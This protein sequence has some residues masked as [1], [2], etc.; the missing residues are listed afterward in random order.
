MKLWQHKVP[1]SNWILQQHY[2]SLLV[3][4]LNA[5]SNQNWPTGF[6]I[7][8]GSKQTDQYITHS[9]VP[10]AS[11]HKSWPAQGLRARFPLVHGSVLFLPSTWLSIQFATFQNHTKHVAFLLI[12]S[13]SLSLSLFLCSNNFFQHAL[14]RGSLLARDTLI[15]AFHGRH[16]ALSL[17]IND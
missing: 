10:I 16:M 5:L 9:S 7:L 4:I 17:F 3:P 14:R 13:H 11:F 6:T 2:D 12:L 15:A 1:F 8:I